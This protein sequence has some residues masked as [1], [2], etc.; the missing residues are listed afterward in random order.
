MST[1]YNKINI[2]KHMS[3]Y[4][5]RVIHEYTLLTLSPRQVAGTHAILTKFIG[6][7]KECGKVNTTKMS[8]LTQA[9]V[10]DI[11]NENVKVK[12]HIKV[13]MQCIFQKFFSFE[14]A[15][16]DLNLHV[17]TQSQI[18]ENVK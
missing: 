1:F 17:L 2:T 7:R 13:R 6:R 3:R 12:E 8:S 5:T 4:L 18:F 11:N 10:S 9:A 16:E 15:N 14:S